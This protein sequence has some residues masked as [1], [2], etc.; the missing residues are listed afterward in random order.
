MKTLICI[1]LDRSGSMGGR[2]SDTV[3]GVNGL[4]KDQQK[5][6]GEADITVYRFDSQAIERFRPLQ[7]LNRFTPLAEH[8]VSARG[9]TPLLDAIGEATD[10]LQTLEKDYERGVL[11]IITD[12]EENESKKFSKAHIKERL[13]KL[14]EAKWGIVYLGADVNAFHEAGQLGIRQTSTAG[15]TKTSKGMDKAYA[16]ASASMTNTRTTGS[17]DYSTNYMNVGGL[18]LNVANLGEDDDKVATP[19]FEGAGG[20][21]AGAGASGS[22][23]ADKQDTQITVTSDTSSTSSDSSTT[24]GSGATSDST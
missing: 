22:W 15:F 9:G 1:I 10:Y 3:G 6:P 16:A 11:A 21:S 17:L 13:E 12:G 14:Q 23:E 8:E 19:P 4:V 18:N 24:S 2:E 5:I 7:P 20:Q